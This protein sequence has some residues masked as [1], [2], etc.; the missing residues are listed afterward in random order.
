MQSSIFSLL[1]RLRHY[2]EIE[3]KKERYTLG[4]D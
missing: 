1:L 2:K 4:A 3:T